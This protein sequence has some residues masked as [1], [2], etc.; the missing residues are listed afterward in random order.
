MEKVNENKIGMKG[1]YKKAGYAKAV[2]YN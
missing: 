1:I 2:L